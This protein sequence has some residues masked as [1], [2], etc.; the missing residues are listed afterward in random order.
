MTLDQ[1][2]PLLVDHLWQ[3]TLF[4]ALALGATLLLGKGPAR[5]R[6]AIW[7]M[8]SA[9]LALP[10][11]VLI[12]LAGAAG[13]DPASPPLGDLSR[14]IDR[15]AAPFTGSP[16]IAPVVEPAHDEGPGAFAVLTLV[17]AAGCAALAAS[18]WRRRRRVSRAVVSSRRIAAGRE[19]AA[20]DQA[21]ARVGSTLSTPL[22][23]S[24]LVE[25]PGVY[26]VL[27]PVV[28]LPEGI[29]GRLSEDELETVLLHELVH[30][31]RRDNLI[32]NLHR[33]LC[34]LFWFYP[35]AWLIERRLLVER[36]RACDDAVLDLS[37]AP[38]VYVSGLLKVSLF[39]L[40][41]RVAGVSAAG[42]CLRERLAGIAAHPS[43]SR[44]GGLHRAI[45]AASATALTL[46]FVAGLLGAGPQ[47]PLT[48]DSIAP[49]PAPSVARPA[50]PAPARVDT[51]PP[52]AIR[53]E[54]AAGSPVRIRRA[55]VRIVPL[56]G[57]E[58]FVTPPTLDLENTSGRRVVFVRIG[59]GAESRWHDVAGFDVE[60]EAGGSHVLRPDW[61]TWSNTVSAGE[62]VSL[63]ARV[64]GVRFGSG[65]TWGSIE[66]AAG[67]LPAPP[68]SRSY[69]SRFEN[70]P[71]APVVVVEARTGA[72]PLDE[73]G[74]SR[75][76]VMTLA[77]TTDRR[78]THLKLRFKAGTP[79]HAV[80]AFAADIAPRGAYTFRSESTFDGD[81][82]RVHIQ[83]LGV[84]F[85]N[86]DIWG[87]FDTTIDTR[88]AT[89]SVPQYI[90]RPGPESD[91]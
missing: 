7:L 63:V 21:R 50:G 31:R 83:V 29:A 79:A 80:T 23:V 78:I 68:P 46:F 11:C 74:Q 91:P 41:P 12:G 28:L 34:C 18:W 75:L 30:I 82:A 85:D 47:D 1:I 54:N 26:G 60:M 16:G 64:V 40:G 15:V 10:S 8:A 53:F 61:R 62:A 22:L 42:S 71:G 49:T 56:D 14:T 25:Q 37:A 89:V 13:I 19:R 55:T 33:V 44:L 4:A 43:G 3:T 5:A 51:A 88:E 48:G 9:K 20:L 87:A 36:E 45:V 2:G 24:P 66:G 57:T 35:V 65:D 52:V 39:C 86:G 38:G 58:D 73:A 59:F 27:S 84:R 67:R 77:N 72:G 32:G 76:P 69:P 81:P 6:Y 90:H 17:W 70:P